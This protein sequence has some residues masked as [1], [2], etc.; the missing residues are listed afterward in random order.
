MKSTDALTPGSAENGARGF[1]AVITAS[2]NLTGIYHGVCR[3]YKAVHQA[4]YLR[5]WPRLLQMRTQRDWLL[6]LTPAFMLPAFD[7][8]MAELADLEAYMADM[9]EVK[10]ADDAPNLVT[11]VGK[12]LAL[13]TILAGSAYTVTGP[14]MFLI[15]AV[16]YTGVPLAADTMSSHT[17]WTEGGGT[18]APTYSGSRPTVSWNSA[19]SGSKSPSARRCSR[20]PAPAR[21]RAS[22]WCWA[23][24]PAR[25]RTTPA[26][27]LYSAGL[28]SGGDQAVVNT[29]TLTITYSA[30]A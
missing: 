27:T 11:T 12:N 10:W 24:A 6:R 4:E 23:L 18:N 7:K 3:G 25:R 17:S 8:F 9:T 26:G 2:L 22:A 13:D 19:S 29:N 30:T 5:E 15:G 28:F 16:S 1:P 14:Y 21:P 20:S